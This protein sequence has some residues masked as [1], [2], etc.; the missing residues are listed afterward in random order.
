[1]QWRSLLYP[2]I[3][4]ALCIAVQVASG[5]YTADL[6]LTGDE[7]SHY[8][9]S[10]LVLDY[11]RQAFPANPLAYARD[12][13]THLPRVSIG[14]WPPAFYVVQA[15]VSAVLGR[16]AAVAI[17]LQGVLAGAAAALVAT[18]VRSRAGW[19]AGLAAGLLVL[20]APAL[21]F[22][23]NAVMLDMALSLL[24]LGAALLWARFVRR[25]DTLSA[26]CFA[27]CATVAILTKGN[28]FGLAL[29]PPLHALLSRD[30][31]PLLAW[32][33]WLA[34][35]SVALFTLPWHLAT[36]RMQASGFNYAFGWDYTGHALPFYAGASLSE[37]GILGVAAVLVG[38]VRIAGSAAGRQDAPLVAVASAAIAM[39]AFALLVPADIVP[40][41]LIMVVPC[42]AVV[43]ATGL[44]WLGTLAGLRPALAGSLAALVLLAD[45]ATVLRWP[46]VSGLGT[47]DIARR[48]LAAPDGGA[49]V[50]VAGAP[51]TEGS[52][53]AAFDELDPAR[54]HYVLRGT[55]QLAGGNFMGTEYHAR[56]ATP[57]E[58]GQWLA[59]SGVGWL[60]VDGTA[61]GQQFLHDRQVAAAMQAAPPG[62]SLVQRTGPAG[63]DLYR[64]EGQATPDQ[65]RALLSR[66]VPNG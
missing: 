16:S 33:A 37:F 30:V 3:F 46:H 4:I 18:L 27:L 19:L 49:M 13:Y 23:M 26:L 58:V 35:A 17:G 45:A 64:H 41:Y 25:R 8:V 22:D 43:A 42:A 24:V 2:A 11:L 61:D 55:Q 9:N 32:Q 15:A 6:G 31:R 14:H 47:Q 62:W 63:L 57:G 52:L 51:R 1:M 66:V 65:Q 60:V 20:A 39:F 12:Y 44:A 56:F 54:S 29:V 40:R 59:G 36:L 28:G 7:A 38:L 21:L 34:A 50:L 48:V 10:L 5:A 53:I